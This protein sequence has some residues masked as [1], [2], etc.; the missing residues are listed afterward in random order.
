MLILFNFQGNIGIRL[1]I[2]V[3]LKTM[4]IVS[5]EKYTEDQHNENQ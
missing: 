1:D 3:T 5:K 4:I 2:R